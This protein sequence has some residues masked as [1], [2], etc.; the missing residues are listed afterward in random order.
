MTADLL[1]SLAVELQ[2]GAHTED[3]EWAVAK[4]EE[5]LQAL[6]QF[7]SL[8]EELAN[9]MQELIKAVLIVQIEFGQKELEAARQG[10]EVTAKEVQAKLRD[11]EKHHRTGKGRGQKESND[12]L[13]QLK[14]LQNEHQEH[15]ARKEGARLTERAG[16][17]RETGGGG[18]G[19][20]GTGGARAKGT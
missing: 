15:E 3:V 6:P 1:I 12:P 16:A 4:Y 20:E 14:E 18:E 19:A 2:L 11:R 5:A 17:A 8:T 13:Q 10:A 9:L 7:T